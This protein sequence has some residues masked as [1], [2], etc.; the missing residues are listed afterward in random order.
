MRPYIVFA[1][2]AG[3]AWGVGG[4]FEKTG[5]RML[6]LTPIIGITLRTAVAL[7]ILG[8]ISIPAWKSLDISSIQPWLMI[9]IGGGVICGKSRHVEFLCFSCND[10]EPQYKLAIAFA[11]SPI[12]GTLMGLARGNQPIDI[13]S[14]LGFLAI[15]TGIVLLQL[16]HRP[17]Q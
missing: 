17:S 14:G 6:G 7:V 15:V 1:I 11:C 13:Q 5:L 2:L 3:V 9:V 4:Y 8:L 10:G 12:A 16:S